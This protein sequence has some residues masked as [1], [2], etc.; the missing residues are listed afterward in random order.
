MSATN[1]GAHRVH[2][3]PGRPRGRRYQANLHVMVSKAQRAKLERIAKRRDISFAE[4][5]REMI[6]D[7]EVAR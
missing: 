3:K 4:M 7:L 2:N 5:V 6:D 1:L